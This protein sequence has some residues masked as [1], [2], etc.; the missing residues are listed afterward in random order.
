MDEQVRV[1]H[2]RGTAPDGSG[3]GSGREPDEW[4][5]AVA[6]S[7]PDETPEADTTAVTSDQVDNARLPL[8]LDRA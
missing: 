2:C 8:A 1:E 6:N 5:V 7:V 4:T 3:A